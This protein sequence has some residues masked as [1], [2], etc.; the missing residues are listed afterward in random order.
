M[1]VNGAIWRKATRSGNNGGEC[2][3]VA[4]LTGAIGIRDSK[5]PH[6][7]NLTVSPTAFSDLLD[8]IRTGKHS[9]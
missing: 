5:H 3:E 4:R 9:R 2:V 8:Q 6:A 7:G 1:D